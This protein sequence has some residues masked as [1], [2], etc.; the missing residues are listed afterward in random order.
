MW[1]TPSVSSPNKKSMAEGRLVHILFTGFCCCCL[2]G[3]SSVSQVIY[4]AA[5]V[6]VLPA[7]VDSFAAIKNNSPRIST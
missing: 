7:A 1:V 3:F 6:T 2:C 4:L 5:T